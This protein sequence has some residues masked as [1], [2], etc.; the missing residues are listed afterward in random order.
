MAAKTGPAS[1]PVKNKPSGRRPDLATLGGLALAVVGILGGLVLEQGRVK[2]VAQLTAAIIVLGGTLGAVMVTTPM[3]VL[4]TAVSQIPSVF[5]ETSH[6]PEAL[7]EQII[8]YAAKARKNGIVSL[9]GEAD[10]VADPFLRKALNLA[11][12]GTDLLELRRMMELEIAVEESRGESA[13]KVY[14]AAG[15]YAP[16]IGII[17]AVLGLIQVMKHLANID[18]VGRGIAV[19]F[20]ATVYG[21]ASAN[22]LFLPAGSKLRSRLQAAV[23]MRELVLEGVLGIAEGLNPKLIRIKLEAYARPPA[24]KKAPKESPAAAGARQ[25]AEAAAGD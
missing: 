4:R 16:T 12:D 14:E 23:Q 11:V 21:V 13:A 10:S 7:I 24:A 2:D 15:G 20:V 25:P 9:E 8:V 19:A 18:E 1:E 3:D 22:I 5:F 17:G 6:A